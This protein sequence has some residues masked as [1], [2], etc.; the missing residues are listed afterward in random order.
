MSTNEASCRPK[1]HLEHAAVWHGC[2]PELRFTDPA[3]LPLPPAI[4]LCS[5]PTLRWALPSLPP[6]LLLAL[7]PPLLPLLRIVPGTAVSSTRNLSTCRSA[8]GFQ[9]L[10]RCQ[11]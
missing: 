2:I 5:F 7:P 6:P 11:A 4:V 3:L 1:Q 9:P 10:G 8:G